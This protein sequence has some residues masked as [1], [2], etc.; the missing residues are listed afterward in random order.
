MWAGYGVIDILFKQVAAAGTAF[1]GNL[2]VAFCLAALLMFGYL[3]YKGSKW[4]TAGIIGG[5]VTA[6]ILTDSGEFLIY[7]DNART[8]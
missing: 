6:T 8:K 2:L 7:D 1:A 3:F 5:L 4:N